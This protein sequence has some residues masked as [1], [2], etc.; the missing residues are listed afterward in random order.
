MYQTVTGIYIQPWHYISTSLVR[1][2]SIESAFY[3]INT[4]EKVTNKSTKCHTHIASEITA[5]VIG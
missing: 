3:G 2:L 5:S 4:W 1:F